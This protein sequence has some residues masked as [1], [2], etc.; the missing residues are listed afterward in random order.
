MRKVITYGTFD[1]LHHGHILLLQ[2]AKALGDHLTVALSSD[3]FNS[4]KGKSSFFSFQQRKLILESI[5]FVDEIIIENSWEQK[6]TDV[7]QLNIDVFVIGDDW[8]G[9]FD[10]LTP[11]CEVVYLPRT[12]HISST[13]IRD[14]YRMQSTGTGD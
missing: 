6:I 12:E 10:F 5:K 2:R 14:H 9:K 8:E 1:L 3:R 13:H 7:Q 4:I 11:Y